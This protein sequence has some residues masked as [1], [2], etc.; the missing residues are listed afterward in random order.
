M[1]FTNNLTIVF[2]LR[3]SPDVGTESDGAMSVQEKS[4]PQC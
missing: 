4:L 3:K 2:I 1:I